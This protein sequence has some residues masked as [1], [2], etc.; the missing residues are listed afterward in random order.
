MFRNVVI[1]ALVIAGSGWTLAHRDDLKDG[2][3][4]SVAAERPEARAFS[5]GAAATFDNEVAI[6]KDG[7]GHFLL[8]AYV[9]GKEIRFLVDTGA[10]E[11]ILS[12]R[13][14]ARAGLNL[15]NL[16]YSRRYRTANGLVSAAPVTL[17]DIRIGQLRVRD[18]DASVNSA[19]MGVSLLGMSFLERLTGYSVRSDRLVLYW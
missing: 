13:D 19:P 8:K 1:L 17:R 16:N 6:R 5:Q 14:A 2:L 4:A 11:V 18:V 7:N 12:E 3:R 10:S 9:N 15:R